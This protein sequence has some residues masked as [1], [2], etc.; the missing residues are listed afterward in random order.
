MIH[1]RGRIAPG[2]AAWVPLLVC[3]VVAA[4]GCLATPTAQREPT[5]PLRINEVMPSNSATIA[6]PSGE[7][8]DWIE[9]YNPSTRA[10]SLEGYALTDDPREPQRSVVGEGV[11]VEPGGYALLWADRQSAQGPTHLGFRL[12]AGGEVL[13]LTA[14]DGSVVDLFEYLRAPTD[15]SFARFP[16]GE[17]ALTL[18]AQPSPGRSNGNACGGA[19]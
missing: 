10:V 16:D 17:G 5:S 12:N 4:S 3:L 14:P 1:V 13:E 6:D 11:V 7:F 9:I 15:F 18:C 19:P 8:D 2:G